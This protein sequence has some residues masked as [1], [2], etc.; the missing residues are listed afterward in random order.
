MGVQVGQSKRK[1][2]QRRHGSQESHQKP[3][4]D[5]ALQPLIEP[6]PSLELMA[7]IQYAKSNGRAHTQ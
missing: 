2:G 1:R 6:G 3:Q 5:G 4:D 7:W